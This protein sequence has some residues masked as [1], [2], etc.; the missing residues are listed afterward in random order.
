[1]YTAE[2]RTL[3]SLKANHEKFIAGAKPKDCMNVVNFPLL[4][5][6]NEDYILDLVYVPR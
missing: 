1:M 3:G 2:L 5:G 6:D 4:R